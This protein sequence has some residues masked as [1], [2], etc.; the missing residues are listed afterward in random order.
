[1]SIAKSSFRKEI[2]NICLVFLFIYGCLYYFTPIY[3][4][5]G[6]IMHGIAYFFM[7]FGPV[8]FLVF[9]NG[10]YQTYKRQNTNWVAYWKDRGY[11]VP[12]HD[13]DYEDKFDEF[14]RNHYSSE[15]TCNRVSD[16]WETTFN[17]LFVIFF[18][19][20]VS[21]KYFFDIHLNHDNEISPIVFIEAFGY[22]IFLFVIPISSKLAC[23]VITNRY[24]GEARRSRKVHPY[25]WLNQNY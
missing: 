25:S 6:S 4:S 10:M 2:I 9:T 19:I 14:F 24:P 18:I 8:V 15:K 21:V 23:K 20:V 1:M 22:V 12:E 13:E 16:A 7:S 11:T 17:V 3:L 5:S